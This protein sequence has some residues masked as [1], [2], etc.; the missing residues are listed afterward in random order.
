MRRYILI[1]TWLVN[2]LL[3]SQVQA[4][5]GGHG[6][7]RSENLNDPEKFPHIHQAKQAAH[8]EELQ[9]ADIHPDLI[10]Q[11]PFDEAGR[12]IIETYNEDEKKSN[13]GHINW[14][15][16]AQVCPQVRLCAYLK[17]QISKEELDAL[18][19]IPQEYLEDLIHR[20]PELPLS[21]KSFDHVTGLLHSTGKDTT[22]QYKVKCPHLTQGKAKSVSNWEE[23]HKENG[24]GCPWSKALDINS[25]IDYEML[26]QQCPVVK[27]LNSA[28][29]GQTS[30]KPEWVKKMFSK[31][32][33]SSP[34][35]NSLLATAY[36]SGPPNLILALVPPNIDVDSLSNLIAFAVGGLLG[37]VFLHLLPQG[38]FR[39]LF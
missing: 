2:A 35:I 33:P 14:H 13:K 34:A 15:R 23:S 24:N 32:F 25:P 31:L 28:K 4:H 27:E 5:G 18:N 29:Q 6:V 39:Y 19:T 3:A 16:A 22:D 9:G 38:M 17:N 11:C 20:C 8:A 37:D 7:L 1:C 26:I 12:L 10:A 30:N 21:E 36:I